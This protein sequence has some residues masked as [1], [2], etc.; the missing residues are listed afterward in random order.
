MLA[1]LPRIEGSPWVVPG[2]TPEWHL[3]DPNHYRNRVRE[4]ADPVDVRIQNLRCSFALL[5]LALC[6]RVVDYNQGDALSSDSLAGIELCVTT[7][8]AGM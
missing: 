5:V 4:E 6:R 1:E 2:Q 3:T 7:E 8:T